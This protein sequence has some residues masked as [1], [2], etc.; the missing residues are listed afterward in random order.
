MK[1]RYRVVAAAFA[2][3]FAMVVVPSA[4]LA[5]P[6]WYAGTAAQWQEKG[7]GLTKAAAVS[8]TESGPAMT[9]TDPNGGPFGEAVSVSC[10]PLAEG[11]QGTGGAGTF[12]A[13]SSKKCT[14]TNKY[15]ETPTLE[16]A[17]LPWNTALAVSAGKVR[18]VIT[19][20][21]KG[22]PGFTAT[23]YYAG[24]VFFANTCTG[25]LSASLENVLGVEA[26]LSGEKL[27]C[28]SGG[29]GTVNAHLY[30]DSPVETGPVYEK[31]K[32]PIEI[33]G[34]GELSITDT[35]F[36]KFGTKCSV[37]VKGA[38]EASGLGKI[39]SYQTTSCKETAECGGPIT[40]KAINLPWKT[41]MY[42]NGGVFE[43]AILSGG[44]GTPEWEFACSYFGTHTSDTCGLNTSFSMQNEGTVENS[45]VKISIS[46]P[47]PRT[48]CAIGGSEAGEW[49]GAIKLTPKPGVVIGGIKVRNE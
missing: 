25:S 40:A 3:T 18:D 39:T 17:H 4:A 37:E 20:S 46:A 35:K 19:E 29:S 32:S 5:A 43:N 22:T 41:E 12:T 30:S 36:G 15:C 7:V 47:S 31:V 34:K 8:W 26:V 42:L 13:W 38:V 9:W 10:E 1:S 23:C 11:T 33:T 28:S 49:E 48:A 6:E 24:K 27:T 14:S 21:G 44:S 2:M 45:S 16:A